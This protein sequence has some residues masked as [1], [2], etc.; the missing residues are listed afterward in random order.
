[1]LVIHLAAWAVV[2]KLF[3]IALHAVLHARLQLAE[4]EVFEAHAL[5]G[6]EAIRHRRAGEGVL[7]ALLSASYISA[8]FSELGAVSSPRPV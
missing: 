2:D 6:R 8:A 3:K 5:P 4:V 7:I 1:M